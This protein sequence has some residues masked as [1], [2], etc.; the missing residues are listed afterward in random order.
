MKKVSAPVFYR[1]C[2]MVW[3]VCWVPHDHNGEEWKLLNIL[4]YISRSKGNK[5][6]KFG[7][8]IE[9]QM[10]NTFPKKHAQNMVE[11]LV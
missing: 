4:L 8:I 11:K 3:S 1:A 7:Q 5:T 10:R 9:Y 6:M 2:T